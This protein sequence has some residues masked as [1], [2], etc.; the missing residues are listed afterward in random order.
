MA[1]PRSPRGAPS[2]RPLPPLSPALSRSPLLRVPPQL[3]SP[4]RLQGLPGAHG[5]L[6]CAM[7]P[8]SRCLRISFT[9]HTAPPFLT[10]PL[11]FCLCSFSG[12]C[13]NC[14]Q[15]WS[16][17]AGSSLNGQETGV[18]WQKCISWACSGQSSLFFP[19]GTVCPPSKYSIRAPCSWAGSWPGVLLFS[20]VLSPW[21]APGDTVGGGC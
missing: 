8:P 10:P 16:N 11:I 17:S 1:E 15:F 4:T 13:F 20:G 19:S 18:P 3:R 21:P 7:S 5:T 9:D 6:R 12:C 2:S 14:L